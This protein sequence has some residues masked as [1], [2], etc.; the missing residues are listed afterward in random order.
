MR[1]P[2]VLLFLVVAASL[3]PPSPLHAA[4]EKFRRASEPV[5]NEYIVV[6]KSYV[7]GRDATNLANS[8]VQTYGGT[9]LYVYQW[10]P[11]GFSLRTS[12]SA[13]I[14][15]S[16]HPDVAFVEQNGIVRSSSPETP[17]ATSNSAGTPGDGE[18]AP[19]YDP[20]GDPDPVD[21]FAGSCSFAQPID[22]WSEDRIDQRFLP[23]DGQYCTTRTGRN[24]NIY[25][26]DTGIRA[27]HSDFGGRVRAHF[28]VQPNPGIPFAGDCQGH[29]TKTAS[30]AAGGRY[31]VAKEATLWSV[32]T[33]VNCSNTNTTI[34]FLVRGI[35]FVTG[36][37][38]KPAVINISSA[39]ADPGSTIDNAVN[40]AI[41]AGIT[42][43]V[44]AGNNNQ[45]A[46]NWTPARVPRALTA[47][48]SDLT[49]L[50]YG[51]QN[52]SDIRALFG[53]GQATNFGPAVDVFAPG[54]W[55]GAAVHTDDGSYDIHFGTS[56]SAPMVAG[57]AAMVLEA[58]T[59]ATPDTVSAAIVNNATLN[60]IIDLPSGTPN[61]LLYSN[62]ID[63]PDNLIQFSSSNYSV[64]EGTGSV[65]ITVTRANTSSAATVSYTTVDDT[66]N[67][68]CSNTS[69][70]I[71]SDRCDYMTTLG[72][73]RFAVGQPSQTFKIFIVDDAWIEGAE[74]TKIVLR[75]PTNGA[76][77]GTPATATLTI[78]DNDTTPRPP[79]QNPT[80]IPESFVRTHYVDFLNREPESNV[81]VN[82]LNNCQGGTDCDRVG[83][84]EAFFKSPEFRIKGYYVYRFYT[85]SLGRIPTFL[86]FT[87]DSQRVTGMTNDETIAN[88]AAFAQEWMLRP[89]VAAKYNPLSNAAYVDEL[90]RLA[91][92][93]NTVT[94]AGVAYSRD[95][96]VNELNA[97]MRS[98]AATLQLIVESGEV[99][100]REFNGAFVAMEYFGYLRRDPEQSGYQAWL[101]FLNANPTQSRE[102]VRGFVNSTEYMLRFG[103]VN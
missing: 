18:Y 63:P 84:S 54:W 81:W 9:V 57:V 43:T 37:H 71:A 44:G 16:G 58:N 85:T 23:R 21:T 22:H 91:Q 20:W 25:I 8:L 55:G 28:D 80:F 83:V 2:L 90:L 99:E 51:A 89:E 38:V 36:N 60:Q 53:G 77:L 52:V 78:T 64:N 29:G 1:N 17:S 97:N 79:N 47:G 102:M 74:T 76:D 12:E 95:R 33:H 93:G 65:T 73:L 19:P 96:L 7:R 101:N 41:D 45:D 68:G 30:I 66:A 27:S 88:R 6:Y 103:P 67:I 3:F 26:I 50:N 10:A 75:S 4:E 59:V 39:S 31:G 82:V 94:N 48:A 46:R 56:M 69:R 72:T 5:T 98:R 34:D 61:R 24:V 14:A 35:N 11:I 62:F 42:V 100:A 32:R 15:L 40:R 86:E 87:A 92:V 70:L 49:D 13:A